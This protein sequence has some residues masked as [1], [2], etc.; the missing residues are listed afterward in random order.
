MQNA[1]AQVLGRSRR[2]VEETSPG[3]AQDELGAPGDEADASPASGWF[4]NDGERPMKLQNTSKQVSKRSEGIS[5]KHSPGRPAEEPD[6]PS[7]ETAVPD[8]VHSTHEGPR[9]VTSDVGG[10]TNAPSRDR[11]PGGHLGDQEEPR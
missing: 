7:G 8:G 11:P 5:Q 6:E 4:E 2:R 3:R 1:L 10:G 9:G